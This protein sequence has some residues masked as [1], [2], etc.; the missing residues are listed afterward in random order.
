MRDDRAYRIFEGG[1]KQNT[2]TLRCEINYTDRDLIPI[3]NMHNTYGHRLYS[4]ILHK[5]GYMQ[6]H[7]GKILAQNVINAFHF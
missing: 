7:I 2:V 4:K 3:S 1:A 6:M 5:I